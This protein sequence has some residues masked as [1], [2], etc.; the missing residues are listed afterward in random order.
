MP[1]VVIVAPLT[2]M[3]TKLPDVG[4]TCWFALRVKLPST[5]VMLDPD[6]S[7]M[8]RAAVSEIAPVPLVA[9]SEL[10]VAKLMPAAVLVE[11]AVRFLFTAIVTA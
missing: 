4:E 6:T 3:P 5:V 2:S 10:V 1:L 11:V 7:E 8:F 9:R